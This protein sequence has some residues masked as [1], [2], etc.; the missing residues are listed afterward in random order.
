LTDLHSTTMRF[1]SLA[2][3]LLS[4]VNGQT[5]QESLLATYG[6]CND[7]IMHVDWDDMMGDESA[8]PAANMTMDVNTDT[9]T[10]TVTVSADFVGWATADQGVDG[11]GMLYM[12]DFAPPDG[13]ITD[14]QDAGTCS[15]RNGA[16]KA[17]TFEDQWTYSADADR[18]LDAA[19][20]AYA[21]TS[22]WALST[23]GD[24]NDVTWTG[25]FGWFDLLNCTDNGGADDYTEIV[26]DDDWVNM[27]GAVTVNLVSPLGLTDTGFYRVYQLIS[28]PFLIAVR[29]TVNVI[30]STG[31]NLF[32]VTVI[33]VYKEDLA[34]DLELVLL[35]EAADYLELE[36][37]QILTNPTPYTLTFGNSGDDIS[38]GCM[39]AGL[40][41]LQLFTIESSDIPCPTIL[42]GGYT[43]QFDLGCNPA[44]LGYADAAA[45]C[46][47]YVNEYGG[48]VTLSTD[49]E[50]TD[51]VCDPLVFLIDFDANLT[52][53][54]N[55][56]FVDQLGSSEQYNL[57]E[58]AYVQVVVGDP[59]DFVPTGVSLDNAWICT[60]HPNNEPLSVNQDLGS[61]GCIGGSIDNGWP[62]HI[63]D[64][65][66]EN[67]EV[68]T[69]NVTIYTD[70]LPDNTVR[71]S[72]PVEFDVERTNLYVHVQASIDITPDARRRRLIDGRQLLQTE[73]NT[74]SNTAHFAGAV[75]IGE[76]V[77]IDQDEDDNDITGEGDDTNKFSIYEMIAMSVA[78]TSVVCLAHFIVFGLCYR[79]K[80]QQRREM[81]LNLQKSVESTSGSRAPPGTDIGTTKK[82]EV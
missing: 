82:V 52:F 63:I 9:L 54:T 36:N 17:G 13:A 46:A 21:E 50:W 74:V 80:S 40:L 60:T 30:S 64:E 23:V 47:N 7:S 66:E 5:L 43:F 48:S 57:G 69:G 26:E 56:S 18:G 81:E 24:C 59:A 8:A 28:Q 72:F 33:A 73:A 41:C 1:A 38:G 29:K 75:G 2:I 70:A 78:A 65:G 58:Q 34:A 22:Q 35:T 16:N 79:K 3:A 51:N 19:D 45:T 10:M 62:K 61:G 11:Y 31:I 25:T 68:V 27:T 76:A 6:A 77:V 32:T 44:I 15:N 37:A 67:D 14:P 12:I 49:F 42:S 39:T 71:F 53:W 55:E 4:G 20:G